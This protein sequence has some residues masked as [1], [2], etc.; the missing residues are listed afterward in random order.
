MTRTGKAIIR[1]RSIGEVDV[2]QSIN[3]GQIF[4]RSVQRMRSATDRPTFSFLGI[5]RTRT[6]YNSSSSWICDGLSMPGTLIAFSCSVAAFAEAS[7]SFSSRKSSAL[8]PSNSLSW[9][10][11]SRTAILKRFASK[12]VSAKA[13]ANASTRLLV[14]V[15]GMP[16]QNNTGH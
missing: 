13:T 9:M 1:R 10:R 12:L 4:Q 7:S 8:S 15:S 3:H 2:I 6:V 16:S 11:K 5:G 14:I